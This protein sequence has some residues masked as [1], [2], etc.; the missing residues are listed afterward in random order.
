MNR[1]T[2]AFLLTGARQVGKTTAVREFARREYDILS[3][4]SFYGNRAAIETVSQAADASDLLFRLS[5]LT[6]KRLEPGKTLLFLDEVQECQDLL[7][8]VKFLA[9]RTGLDIVL[10]GSL[11]GLDAL[12]NVRSLPVGFLQE[13]IMFPLDFEEFCWAAGLA[14]GAF[15]RLRECFSSVSEV[16]GFLH[17]RL[18]DLFYKYLLIGGMPDAV[19]AFA[20]SS[21][22]VPVR[23]SQRAIFDL[24]EDD[25]AKYVD[26]KLEARQIKMIYES[27][28]GQLN[29][30]SKR[31]KYARLEKNL[32]FV[33]METAFDWLDA[34]GVAL[35]AT[36][37]GE[38]SFPL[39]L[40]EDRSSF[41]L[42]MNDVGLLTSRLMGKA[43]LDIVNRTSGVNYGSIFENAVAQELKAHG[44]RLHYFASKKFGEVDFVVEDPDMGTV[45]PIEVKSGKDYKRHSALNNLLKNPKRGFE[46]AMVLCDGNVEESGPITYLPIYMV[47]LIGRLDA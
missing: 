7:T 10:S 44:F 29:A 27:I 19:Q 17:D 42:F 38:T 45:I 24:Y 30:P 3:E 26:S 21:E 8:W 6:G 20:S 40:S 39:G 18:I 36:R 25:M 28:P 31:F 16:P 23:N 46:K 9:E 12:V 41:K 2:Q 5:V 11:L 37:V 47:S 22:I 15:D 34:A 43:A 35:S 14:D 1:T 33:N 13:H 4:V 32:R